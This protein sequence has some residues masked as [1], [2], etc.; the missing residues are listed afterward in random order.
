MNGIMQCWEDFTPTTNEL[1]AALLM[2][3]LP[4]LLYV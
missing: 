2:V 4:D 1:P 3:I